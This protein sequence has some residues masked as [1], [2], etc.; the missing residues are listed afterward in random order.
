MATAQANS[1][2]TRA[3]ARIQAPVPLPTYGVSD[4]V[5]S[6]HWGLS[7]SERAT[8]K[9]A[10]QILERAMSGGDVFASPLAVKQYISLHLAGE[11]RERFAVLFLNAQHRALAFDMMFTGTLTQTSVYTREIVLAALGYGAAAVVLAHNH[12]SGNVQPSRADELLTQTIKAALALV[13]VRV[14]DHIIVAP[15]GALS[16]AEKGLV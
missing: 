7:T 14:L 9:S 8:I 12:P 4:N 11:R 13:D 16:M 5:L 10:L 2:R 6:F 15:G 1:V 3:P